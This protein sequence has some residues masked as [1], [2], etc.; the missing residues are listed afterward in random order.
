MKYAIR[1][2]IK[3]GLGHEQVP[4][5]Y[6]L[7]KRSLFSA[8]R[9]ARMAKRVVRLLT[10]RD[11]IYKLDAQPRKKHFGS[12]YGGWTIVPEL[13]NS[14][15]IVYSFGVG[16]DISFDLDLIRC[17]G[18]TVHG[19]D[20][21]A[22]AIE[23]LATQNIP[24]NYIFHPWG[25]GAI[26]GQADFFAPCSGSMYS[27]HKEHIKEKLTQTRVTI[28]RLSTIARNLG[29]EAIDLLKMDVEG[30]EYDVLPELLQSPVPVK[31]LLIEFHHRTGIESL[32]VTVKSVERLRDAGFDL[33]HVSETSSEFSFLRS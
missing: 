12:I 22:F 26:D 27:L 25:L 19:F 28:H 3:P 14:R 6:K 13:I 29:T 31:Q 5:C 23:W 33:F 18:T 24:V 16:D 21:S 11:V 32:A 10:G 15:T 8:R 1:S 20:P 4:V 17:F 9:Y 7:G 30:A 2:A